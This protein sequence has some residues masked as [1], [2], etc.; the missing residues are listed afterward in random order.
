M[1]AGCSCKSLRH[2]EQV[3]FSYGW[4]Y[5][6]SAL[7][8]CVITILF[9][10]FISDSR[11]SVLHPRYKTTWFEKMKWEREWIDTAVELLK[12]TYDDYYKPTVTVLDA[13]EDKVSRYV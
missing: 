12:T 4:I 6:V 5:Y 8:E 10:F 2:F 11:F 13:P 1:Y 3:L 9:K 7:H